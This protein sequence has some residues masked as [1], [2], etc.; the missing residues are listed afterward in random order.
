[1]KKALLNLAT[2]ISVVL[3]LESCAGLR[4]MVV[5]IVMIES[6][7]ETSKPGWVKSTKEFWQKKGNYYYRGISQGYKDL[8][9]SKQDAEAIA[10][11]NLARQIKLVLRDEFARA[12]EAQKADPNIGGYLKD[13]F[14]MVV[15]NLDVS[16]SVLEH[17]YNERMQERTKRS[18]IK[19]YWRSYVLVKLP[20]EDFERAA[21]KAFEN[22]KEQVQ[23]NQSAKELAEKVEEH[24]WEMEKQK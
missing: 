22:L 1:M 14:V 2:I 23:A 10:R 7:P 9:V 11:I 19:D 5:E 21:K 8:E 12:V 20:R 4:T 15:V 16:G 13:A 18:I 6:V 3:L 24:F 17:S